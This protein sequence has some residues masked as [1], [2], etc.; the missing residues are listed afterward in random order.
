M[1][2]YFSPKNVVLNVFRFS[3]TEQLSRLIGAKFNDETKT[4]FSKNPKS[5][6]KQLQLVT[7]YIIMLN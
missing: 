1:R 4:V 6:I 7:Y 2:Q 5:T 3:E